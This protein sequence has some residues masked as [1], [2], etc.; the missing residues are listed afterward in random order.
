MCIINAN[1]THMLELMSFSNVCSA[2]CHKID[3][4]EERPRFLLFKSQQGECIL[5]ITPIMPPKEFRSQ[6]TCFIS[7]EPHCRARGTL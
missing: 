4:G 3:H 6:L 7:F 2:I 1:W 5:A